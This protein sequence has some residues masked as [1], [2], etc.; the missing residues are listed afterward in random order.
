[1]YLDLDQWTDDVQ[2]QTVDS[3]TAEAVN[4]RQALHHY[5]NT[6]SISSGKLTLL[7]LQLATVDIKQLFKNVKRQVKFKLS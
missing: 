5:S 2:V 3:E 4:Q 1:M 6:I 7:P